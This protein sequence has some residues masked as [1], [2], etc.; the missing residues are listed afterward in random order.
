MWSL[1]S[2][3]GMSGM[4]FYCEGR[5]VDVSRSVLSVCGDSF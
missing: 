4:Q 3:S 5:A 2:W 1:P